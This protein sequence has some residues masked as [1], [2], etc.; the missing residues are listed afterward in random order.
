MKRFFVG[1]L[2]LGL[3]KT[4]FAG[5]YDLK[6]SRVAA[7]DEEQSCEAFIEK[8][9]DE[10]AAQSKGKIIDGGCRQDEF[11]IAGWDAVLTYQSPARLHVTST[12]KASVYSSAF[13]SSR[14]SCEDGLELQ[15]KLFTSA[16]GLKPLAAYCMLDVASYK[17]W[18]TR[19][20]GLGSSKVTSGSMA[21]SF[22]GTIVDADSV[23]TNFSKAAKGHDISIFEAGQSLDSVNH[24]VLRYYSLVPYRIAD[25]NA[26][27]YE[28]AKSCTAAAGSV[29]NALKLASKP[30]VVF[31][32]LSKNK[33]VAILHA[34]AF[35]ELIKPQ[36]VFDARELATSFST[37]EACEAASKK[38]GVTGDVL[39]A[40]CAG[41]SANFH[42][43]LFSKP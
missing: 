13:Y 18:I 15:K 32:E 43:H 41:S 36:R 2:F 20:D 22:F 28:D 37:L 31:C 3:A 9:A 19:I 23:F 12:Y 42:I 34:T 35:E 25:Y 39:G 4:S 17:K 21:A 38:V 5:V 11:S 1:I 26:M 27:K 14:K 7:L 29:N 40:V 24:L 8:V 6:F 30:A 16:T 33:K 10:F